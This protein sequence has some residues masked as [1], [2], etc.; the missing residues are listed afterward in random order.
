MLHACGNAIKT[1]SNTNP[2]P[3]L[4][5]TLATARTTCAITSTCFNLT[6]TILATYRISFSAQR[7]NLA[8][9]GKRFVTV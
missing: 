1:Y 9:L 3:R 2:S 4:I 8:Y 6:P 5:D 7:K